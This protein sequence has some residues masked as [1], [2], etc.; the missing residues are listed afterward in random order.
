MRWNQS[1]PE[2]RALERLLSA[3]AHISEAHKGWRTKGGRIA[4]LA[5]ARREAEQAI[6][7]IERAIMAA[8]GWPQPRAARGTAELA[9]VAARA[10]ALLGES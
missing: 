2:W 3:V 4:D 9:G 5:T 10:R 1:G 7:D 6:E 8:E